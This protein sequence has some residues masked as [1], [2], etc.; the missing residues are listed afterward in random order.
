MERL[1]RGPNHRDRVRVDLK[2]WGE[3]MCIEDIRLGR[4]T[5][6]ATT[7]RSVG[8]TAVQLVQ[9]ATDRTSLLISCAVGD[10]IT[11]SHDPGVTD[12]FGLVL[13]AAGSPLLLDIRQHGDIVVGPIYAVAS[14]GT[15][16]V[17]MIES[18]QP[19]T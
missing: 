4:E 16:T 8:T 7:S 15:V 12:Q 9:R 17:G 3:R 2:S 11:L 1:R 18:F 14:A 10:R 5:R 6:T 19:A 13:H